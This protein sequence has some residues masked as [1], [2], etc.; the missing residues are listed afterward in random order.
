MKKIK[1]LR[2]VVRSKEILRFAPIIAMFIIILLMFSY[3]LEQNSNIGIWIMVS[4]LCMLNI[5]YYWVSIDKYKN[6]LL[7]PFWYIFLFLYIIQ[8]HLI[9]TDHGFINLIVWIISVC[10]FVWLY[11][12]I[13]KVIKKPQD[14]EKIKNEIFLGLSLSLKLQIGDQSK[15]YLMNFCSR[16]YHLGESEELLLGILLPYIKDSVILK[17]LSKCNDPEQ[18]FYTLEGFVEE[19]PFLVVNKLIKTTKDGALSYFESKKGDYTGNQFQNSLGRE[20][21]EE[22]REIILEKNSLYIATGMFIS[23]L[24]SNKFQKT[25][26]I[27][28][29]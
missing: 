22:S 16:P 25:G 18:I 9:L 3:V 23:S 27:S 29:P 10:F 15:Y 7:N 6:F 24:L 2:K 1:F 14:Y 26:F 5:H 28:F 21:W 19:L 20:L 8:K 12:I 11:F 13:L 17:N 4:M